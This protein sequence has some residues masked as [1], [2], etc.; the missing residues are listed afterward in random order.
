MIL[1]CKQKWLSALLPNPCNFGDSKFSDR[2]SNVIGNIWFVAHHLP[3]RLEVLWD[4][5][6]LI[7]HKHVLFVHRCLTYWHRVTHI[8]IDYLGD[9]WF[10][11]WL[12]AWSVPSRYVNQ[13]CKFVNSMKSQSKCIYLHSREYIW[14]SRQEFGGHFVS[15]SL[16]W[17]DFCSGKF[18]PTIW[19]GHTFLAPDTTRGNPSFTVPPF[20][21]MV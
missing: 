7:S 4:I 21:N 5:I 6:Y 20:T 15:A 1:H 19:H 2:I 18:L 9:H 10:R 8:C 14:R 3:P 11:W 16:C 12:V 17:Y 13:C